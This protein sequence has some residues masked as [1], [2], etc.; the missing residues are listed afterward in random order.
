MLS[1]WVPFSVQRK[2]CSS[3]Q[4][5][6]NIFIS[7][8]RQCM[9]NVNTNN[10][11]FGRSGHAQLFFESAISIPQL[12]GSTSAIAIPQLLKKCCSAMAI[13]SEVRNLRVSLPQ[14]SAIF[15]PRSSLKL[16]IFLPPGVLCY[17]EYFKGA[18]ARDF[19]PLFFRE[20]T[21]YQPLSNTPKDFCSLFQIA[22]PQI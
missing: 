7:T 10:Y 17:S 13:F 18:V 6:Q 16:D 2:F 14:F 11:V 8:T 1:G 4:I 22:I 21:S 15:W 3:S 5:Y 9:R 20:S 12:A 19:R